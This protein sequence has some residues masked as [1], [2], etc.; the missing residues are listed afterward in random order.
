MR[1]IP[2]SPVQ[3]KIA[4]RAFK[5]QE[6]MRGEGWTRNQSIEAMAS[7]MACLH[8]ESEAGVQRGLESLLRTMLGAWLT[9]RVGKEGA[10]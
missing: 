4:D 2:G 1:A 3:R 7:L 10:G 8:E 6:M 9:A 5:L